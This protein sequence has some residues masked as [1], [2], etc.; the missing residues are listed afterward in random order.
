MRGWSNWGW[1]LGFSGRRGRKLR[2]RPR[3]TSAPRGESLEGRRLLSADLA[4]GL[5]APTTVLAGDELV[6]SLSV[7]NQGPDAAT[8]VVASDTLPS[9]VTFVNWTTSHL[10]L[11]QTQAPPPGATG[12]VRFSVDSLAGDQGF[13]AQIIV[14]VSATL[15]DGSV[16]A[17][18]AQ[19]TSDTAD[20]TPDDDTAS[21]STTVHPPAL[22]IY[23]KTYLDA[24]A[25]GIRQTSEPA[26][27]LSDVYIDLNNNGRF[28]PGEPTS[29]PDQNGNYQFA[30]AA[31]GTYTVREAFEPQHGFEV[32]E[33]I[34]GGYTVAA[35]QGSSFSNLDF[36]DVPI[37]EVVPV[38]VVA[39]RFTPAHD[40]DSAI[41]NGVYRNVLG[42]DPD[43]AGL[44]FFDQAL[45]AGM[46]RDQL[47]R[48]VW[49]SPEHRAQEVSFFFS[50]YLHRTADPAGLNFWVAALEASGNE[51]PVVIGFVTS[52]EYQTAHASTAAYVT[53]LYNDI[54]SHAPDTEGLDNWIAALQHGSSRAAVAEAVIMSHDSLG[55]LS[56]SL[57]LSD[58]HRPDDPH[59]RVLLE[60]GL[61]V[62]RITP[63][64]VAAAIL[65]SDEYLAAA[66]N[67]LKAAP[68]DG[69]KP[70]NMRRG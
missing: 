46:S 35:G 26:Y 6:Y 21:V 27:T 63:G 20:P 59:G 13:Q 30:L 65:A 32:T 47:V 57:Y 9:G 22:L 64:D 14:R 44:A 67:A 55:Q 51:I 37:N 23:G 60:T 69:S 3:R 49:S 56:N 66:K 15:A 34:G 4:V 54:L 70:R 39:D 31:P 25:D 61:E 2:A 62:E 28:D 50:N 45:A 68:S 41:V 48:D 5:T 40:I 52:A 18:T 24:N 42:R 1:A 29:T 16:L 8:N 12:T 36:G 19:V 38:Q 17:D 58:L 10:P 53:A 7:T 43:S 33:P 11:L